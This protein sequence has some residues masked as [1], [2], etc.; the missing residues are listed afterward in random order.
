MLACGFRLLSPIPAAAPWGGSRRN[1]LFGWGTAKTGQDLPPPPAEQA[2]VMMST[3][4][5]GGSTTASF[6]SPH[7]S[8]EATFSVVFSVSIWCRSWN[9]TRGFGRRP[10]G[11]HPGACQSPGSL[12]LAPRPRHSSA[13]VALKR[14]CPC[15]GP[16]S[17]APGKQ[18]D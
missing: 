14:S 18:M 15:R 16:A 13:E 11:Q 17:P 8:Q 4:G 2:F 7:Q 6:P 12:L 5:W 1:V 10:G 9:K 3:V